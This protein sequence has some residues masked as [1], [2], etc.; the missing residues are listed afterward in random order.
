M[1]GA[2]NGHV[3]AAVRNPAAGMELLFA[4]P[5]GEQDAFR[6]AF[7]EALRGLVSPLTP[8]ESMVAWTAGRAMWWASRMRQIE[9]LGAEIVREIDGSA[10]TLRDGITVRR[11]A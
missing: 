8:E 3:R 9:R 11:T 4:F 5:P 2:Q 7:E 10:E 6:A 1:A